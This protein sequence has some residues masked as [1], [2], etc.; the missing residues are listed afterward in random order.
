MSPER[1]APKMP[2]NP[3]PSV[4]AALMKSIDM[5]KMNCITASLYRRRNH[6]VRRGIM[7]VSKVHTNTIFTINHVQ[8]IMPPLPLCADATAD[9]TTMARNSAIIVE[10]TLSVTLGLR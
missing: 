3:T 4:T 6:R 10:P 5:M 8:N 9:I 1:N 2:S 7:M